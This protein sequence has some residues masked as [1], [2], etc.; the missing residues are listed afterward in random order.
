VGFDPGLS[1]AF[2]EAGQGHEAG[3]VVVSGNVEAAQ[4]RGKKQCRK[5]VG[6]ERSSHR[7][8][9]QARTQRQHGLDT[10]ADRSCGA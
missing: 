9:G 8:I 5:V 3:L 7:Q 2:G 10:L 6:G 4:C 1:G